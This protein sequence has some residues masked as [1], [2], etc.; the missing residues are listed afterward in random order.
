MSSTHGSPPSDCST[1]PVPVTNPYSPESTSVVVMSTLVYASTSAYEQTE[2]QSSSSTVSIPPIAFETLQS[3]S[4]AM[5]IPPIAIETSSTVDAEENAAVVAV[6]A[7]ETSSTSSGQSKRLCPLF[8]HLPQCPTGHSLA[9]CVVFLQM[10]HGR[11]F[12]PPGELDVDVDDWP[13]LP[14]PPSLLRPGSWVL[15]AFPFRREPE[16]LPAWP[17][18]RRAWSPED[19]F[20]LLASSCLKSVDSKRFRTDAT[21]ISLVSGPSRSSSDCFWK[22]YSA[23]RAFTNFK[24]VWDSFRLMPVS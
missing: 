3:S 11:D 20:L 19:T 18:T 6:V 22:L 15:P 12:H 8:P 9:M 4:P 24:R 21:T 1:P 7:T 5:S 16:G 17:F 10:K 23:G 14:W 13:L 2:L